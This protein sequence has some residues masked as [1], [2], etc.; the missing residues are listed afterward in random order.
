MQLTGLKK[1]ELFI[2]LI[3]QVFSKITKITLFFSGELI[4]EFQELKIDGVEHGQNANCLTSDR[5][6]VEQEI[7]SLGWRQIRRYCGDWNGQLKAIHVVTK[8]SGIRI[9]SVLYPMH[10]NEK[11][12]RGFVAKVGHA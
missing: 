7:R 1:N 12:L 6:V 11:S 9:G 3:L 5:I 4:I 8:A 10:K 2:N